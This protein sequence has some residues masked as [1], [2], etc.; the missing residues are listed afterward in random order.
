MT[1][2]TA[3]QI[4]NRSG[5]GLGATTGFWSEDDARKDMRAND[6]GELDE[7]EASDAQ[8]NAVYYERR[9]SPRP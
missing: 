6:I 1:N 2:W 8:G 3:G 9:T 7:D 4:E 5:G